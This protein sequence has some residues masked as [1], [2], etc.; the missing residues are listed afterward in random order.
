MTPEQLEAFQA[1]CAAKKAAEL[2]AKNAQH[3]E[4]VRIR[5]ARWRVEN[6]EKDKARNACW[7][8]E[9]PEKR[10]AHDACYRTANSEK[11]KVASVR[12]SA[13]NPEK[14]R[15]SS[16]RNSYGITQE[17]WD[18]MFTAQGNKCGNPGCGVSKSNTALGWHTDHDHISGKVRGILCHSCNVGLGHFRDDIAKLQGAIEYLS[19]N[20]I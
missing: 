17:Q 12:W 14:K 1:K 20:R 9:N 7:R 18:A 19:R 8:A 6:P 5:N 16:L 13:E 10:K 3:R 11:R 2:E 15:A 4:R